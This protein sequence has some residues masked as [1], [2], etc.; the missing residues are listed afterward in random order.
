M[1]VLRRQAAPWILLVLMVH[2]TVGSAA[3]QDATLP[4]GPVYLEEDLDVP[5]GETLRVGPGTVVGGSRGILVSGTLV[6]VGNASARAELTVNVTVLPGGAVQMQR[7]RLYN[8]HGTALTV[9]SGTAVLQEVLFEANNR[10]L[11]VGGTGRVTAADVTLRDHSDEAVYMQ[12][13]AD[14]H[15]ERANVTGN[16]RGITAFSATRLLVANSTFAANGQHVVVDLGPW[17]VTPG[18]FAL[19]EN[20]FL[21]PTRT[22][23]ALPGILLRGDL[24][25]ADERSARLVS[26]AKNH[27]EGAAVGLRAEGRGLRVTSLDDTFVDNDVGLSHQLATV[28]IV[29][30]TFRNA[31]DLESGGRLVSTDTTFLGGGSATAAT[32][33]APPQ[34][35]L[36]RWAP[37]LL[38]GALLV[39]VGVFVASR[40]PRGRPPAAPEPSPSPL[41]S[42]QPP[43]PPAEPPTF[44]LLERRILEDIAAHP[45][46]PQRAVADRL[47]YTRQALHYHVKKLEA[48]GLVLKRTE[49]RETHCRVAPHAL[50]AL[51]VPAVTDTRSGEKA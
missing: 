15:I 13:S 7:A 38:G 25:L 34:D 35:G 2:L 47:G 23:A 37:W 41:P 16:S 44:T 29:G 48:R 12:D 9:Q 10:A 33:E 31:R 6:V 43:S 39:V 49:G 42:P 24:P 36:A 20:R 5:A 3:A 30:G 14:V 21:A 19:E 50:P 1:L 8:V 45:D 26:L 32:L 27:V 46:T 40:A 51:S 11:A 4:P 22:A 17:S 18:S 28:E